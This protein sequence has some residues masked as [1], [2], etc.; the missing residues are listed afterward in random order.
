VHKSLHRSSL[1]VILLGVTLILTAGGCEKKPS[2]I[3]TQYT[4]T[5]DVEGEGTVL[6]PG[7]GTYKFDAGTVVYMTVHS[8]TDY[9]FQSWG[10][11]DG[12]SVTSS[13]TI[14]MDRNKSITAI[15]EKLKYPVDVY[16]SPENTGT[17]DIE[18]LGSAS[19]LYERGQTIKLTATA[20]EGYVFERWYVGIDAKPV[21]GNPI[22]LQVDGPKKV[23]ANFKSVVIKITAEPNDARV[24]QVVHSLDSPG[25]PTVRVTAGAMAVAD[26]LVTV[27]EKSGQPIMGTT[28]LKTDA[29]GYATFSDLAFPAEG[30]F[31]LVFESHGKIIESKSFDVLLAGIGTEADPYQIH[32][33]YGMELMHKNLKAHYKIMNDID[34]SASATSNPKPGS[35]DNYLGWLPLGQSY[36]DAE[37]NVLYSYFTGTIDGNNCTISN[38]YINYNSSHGVGF[39]GNLRGGHIKD[40]HL[41]DVE[42][43]GQYSVGGLV[44]NIWGGVS[45]T[46]TVERCS[47]SG[48]VSGINFTGGL[49]GQIKDNSDAQVANCWSCATVTCQSVAGGM[50]GDCL[51]GII[52]NC[53]ATGDVTA[54]RNPYTPN[55][56]YG[57]GG[58]CGG[59]TNTVVSQCYATGNVAAGEYAGGFAA[60]TGDSILTDCYARGTVGKH[61][62]EANGN[63]MGSFIGFAFD[64]AKIVNCYATGLVTST[65]SLISGFFGSV[66]DGATITVTSC[67]YDKDTTGF[68]DASDTGKGTPLS[69]DAMKLSN[70]YDGW[71]FPLI[72]SI[73]EGFNDG[74]PSLL[75][76][77]L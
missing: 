77:P 44:G 40:L 63:H 12:D 21:D 48:A 46:S 4:L 14:L 74:Y 72:W 54:N 62:V 61:V 13:G 50:I 9:A 24:N 11:P 22:D 23:T 30:E 47:S 67:Y 6:N 56:N 41:T 75:N 32:N 43:L 76:M 69:T 10:G 19:A 58:F 55:D 26:T 60:S 1:I 66:S 16:V 18:I 64:G 27:T 20:N 42:I 34:A 73:F 25:A 39:V 70:S 28:S 7:V 38:L 68:P 8:G 45:S 35:T 2:V 15:F 37:Q 5:V 3:P 65:S 36:R 17:V 59:F 33:Y 29:S 71:D 51:D 49:I 53:Y 31:M 52:N 57:V